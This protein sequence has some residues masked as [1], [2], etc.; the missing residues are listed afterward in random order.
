VAT[1]RHSTRAFASAPVRQVDTST[2]DE[3][4]D[5][6]EGD[7]RRLVRSIPVT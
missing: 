1:I 4:G 2:V 3:E 5:E 6:A 7:D